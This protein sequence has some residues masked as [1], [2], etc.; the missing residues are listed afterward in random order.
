M[1]PLKS[2]VGTI[3]SGFV[4]AILIVVAT[5]GSH[6][7]LGMSVNAVI[8]W[9]HVLAG[10]TWIG[11]LYYFNFVQVPALAEAVADDGG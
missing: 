7:F 4:L 6:I 8:I 5:R 3:V 11:L 9:A 10:I 1:N 2:V